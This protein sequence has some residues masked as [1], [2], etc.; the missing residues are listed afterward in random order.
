MT[1]VFILFLSGQNTLFCAR[2]L[3]GYQSWCGYSYTIKHV[4]F[5]MTHFVC[6]WRCLAALHRSPDAP[7]RAA[8]CALPNDTPKTNKMG[9]IKGNML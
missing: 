6:F 8:R 9:H 4:S 1:D 2:C 3:S 7:H 5:N